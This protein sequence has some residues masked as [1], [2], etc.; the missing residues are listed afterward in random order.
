M[1]FPIHGVPGL[2]GHTKAF[3]SKFNRESDSTFVAGSLIYLRKLSGN[4]FIKLGIVCK[5]LFGL[6]L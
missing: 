5:H 1:C 6:N 2:G 3:R 4:D